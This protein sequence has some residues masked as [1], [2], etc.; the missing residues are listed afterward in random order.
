MADGDRAGL[1]VFRDRS[2]YVGVHRTGDSFAVVAAFNMTIDEW[3]GATLDLGQVVEQVAVPA[4]VKKVWL[5]V[6]LDARASG[7]HGAW[8]EYSL[9]GRGFVKVGGVYEVYTGWAFFL[10]YRFGVFNH[11]TKALGGSVKVASFATA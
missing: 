4:G 7:D 6:G 9:D 8:F 10:G 5:K 2:A 3:S 1:A 11:A